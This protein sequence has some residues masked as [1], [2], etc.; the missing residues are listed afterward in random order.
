MLVS[1]SVAYALAVVAGRATRLAGGEVALV[2]PA[3]AVAIIWLLVTRRC[4][5]WERAVHVVMLGVLTFVM[6]V[7][8]G[9]PTMLSGWFALVNV[10]LSVVTVAVLT[11]RRRDAVLRDPADLARLTAAVVA[12]ACAG[13][14]LATAFLAMA[15]NAPVWQTF[16][17][18]A[19]RNGTSALLGLAIWLRLHDVEWKRPR[20]S[21]SSVVEGLAVS[22][23]MAFVFFW[24][25][26]LNTGVPMAFLTLVAAMWLA[27][28]Y[29][30]T[31]NMTFL[32]G[33]G[34]WIVFATLVNRGVFIVPD[35]AARAMLSQA[36]VCS[37]TVIVLTLS[38]YRDSRRR[39][40]TQLRQ[41]RDRADQ[42]SELL[43]AVL[44]SIHDSVMVVDPSGDV[45]LRNSRAVADDHVVR[46]LVSA[47][48]GDDPGDVVLDGE[49]PRVIELKTAPLVRQPALSVMAFRDVTAERKHARALREAR[50]LFAGV[51]QAA[52]EQAIVGFDPFGCITVFN[53]GAERLLGWTETEMLGRSP[54]EFHLPSE[55]RA[56]A[57]EL[58]V[59]AGFEVFVRDVTPETAQVR[60]WTF[61]RRDG[62][63]AS[64]SLAVS[65]MT[66]E[67]GSCAGYIGVATDI[68]E[69]KAAENALAES[70]E[71]FRLA[72]DTAPMGMF[73]FDTTP[74]PSGRVTRCNQ[75][76]A[77]ILGRS[78]EDVLGTPVTSLGEVD[79]A[80]SARSL[81]ELPI[82]RHGDS[83]EG[84]IAFR[85]AD[86]ATVWG[87]VSA[88]LVAPPGSHPYGICLV[89]DVTIRK[90]AEAE[91][92]H[93]ASHDRLTGLANR[94]LFMDCVEHALADSGRD[95]SRRVGVIFLDLDGF[96]AVNDTWG[97][98]QGDQVLE[99]VARRL[100]TSIRSRD[101]AAR[102]GGDEFAVLC[103]EITDV[104]HLR[105]V[106]ERILD[107]LHRPVRLSGGGTYDQLSASCG[108]AMSRPG[109]TAQKLLQQA[110][111]LMYHAKHDGKDRVA[112]SETPEEAAMY[113]AVQLVP[114]LERAVER[115]EF[116]VRFQPIVNLRTGDCVAAEAL[117]R[118]Q[119]P[120]RG[121][122]EPDDFLT[123]AETSRQMPA[124][125]RHVLY[126]ACR[127]A[128]LWNAPMDAAAVHVN[129]SG[130]QLE[131][132]DFR[133]DVLEA[134]QKT[135]LTPNRL[136]LELTE[137]Y[138]GR[139]AIRA[140]DDL[141][142]LRRIG[143]RTAIDD[144][145]TGFSGLAKIV[146][147][148]I[149][150]LKI[151]KQFIGG[152]PRDPRCEAIT[153]AVLTLG[154]SLG[155]SVIAEGIEVHE[156]CDLLAQ[157][158][159]EL[160]QG[161]LFGKAVEGVHTFVGPG[162]VKTEKD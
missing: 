76:M 28:R 75:A 144:V 114:E 82:L 67:D 15:S 118:W 162:P 38:L 44:D 103:P 145:G 77:R 13:A 70:E 148:P 80:S 53:N 125:G 101:T 34:A 130:R 36:M 21:I 150:I 72:F 37:L 122:L 115:G 26:W 60:E 61:V 105:A 66:A 108:V 119:H 121:L 133:A 68:T 74:Q 93:M 19:V 99:T 11:H 147:L 17:L 152:L 16:A 8:T 65:Q 135:G 157:W 160:G 2:W 32:A 6:N 30:T 62:T 29:S 57:A 97:H 14:V 110:D 146:D 58:G 132:G 142:R 24:I 47:S 41:A 154:S 158:G 88:S 35:V 55:V 116:V 98:A 63:H 128:R 5:R 78:A 56:R 54:L 139:V 120:T 50:D 117:L 79:F 129:V 39:L 52:S 102:L 134:L 46:D 107:E 155:L 91:L 18:F 151:D 7:A 94:V 25:F 161:F 100:E 1:F 4:G 127:R 124:I 45:V 42:D 136:V 84:E 71:R 12:G 10:T 126:E 33:T 48:P 106:A 113:R 64:V 40:V 73:M 153:R 86:G 141:E 22:V 109:C 143:V 90:L 9:A 31:V 20:T 51:L 159:C 92:R 83:F 138:A 23:G 96:K 95:E 156:Q 111:M 89:E 131:T 49:P 137:T 149:D 123:A 140:K 43:G 59:A 104:A 69:Q 27:L 81:D 85:R 87:A 112:L 3:A